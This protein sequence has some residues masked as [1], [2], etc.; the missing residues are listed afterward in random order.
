M[1]L[2]VFILGA[3]TC[4]YFQ[5]AK[6]LLNNNNSKYRIKSI[7]AKDN[8]QEYKLKL[9]TLKQNLNDLNITQKM[10]NKLSNMTSSPIVL[11]PGEEFVGGCDDLMEHVKKK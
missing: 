5:A 10:K 3:T 4:S 1:V 9:N 11:I 8:L 7:Y 2:D 6:R